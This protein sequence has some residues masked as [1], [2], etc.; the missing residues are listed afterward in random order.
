MLLVAT[1]LRFF[2]AFFA[3]N[4]S[5]LTVMFDVVDELFVC[6]LLLVDFL[7]QWT[8]V[9]SE[10]VTIV[11]FQVMKVILIAINSLGCFLQSWLFF[12]FLCILGFR[13]AQFLIALFRLILIV[14]SSR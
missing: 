6:H 14:S 8:R 4:Q 13:S 5:F 11:I 2:I 1:S 7:T 10:L 3:F 12:A 9:D